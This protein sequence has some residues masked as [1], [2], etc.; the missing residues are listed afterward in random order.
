[1]EIIVDLKKK[2]MLR[3]RMAVEFVRVTCV[4]N[5]LILS[6]GMDRLVIYDD[7]D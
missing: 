2:K 3:D 5:V 6:A 7:L 4:E 1:M